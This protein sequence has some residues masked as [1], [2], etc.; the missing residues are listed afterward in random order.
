VAVQAFGPGQVFTAELEAAAAYPP[1]PPL[2]VPASGSVESSPVN[3]TLAPVAPSTPTA[4]AALDPPAASGSSD[5]DAPSSAFVFAVRDGRLGS[6]TLSDL[7]AAKRSIA[8]PR[9][10]I[11]YVDQLSVTAMVATGSQ[12]FIGD[13]SGVLY[14]WDTDSGE[15]MVV[16]TS[17]KAIH[18]IVLAPPAPQQKGSVP[19]RDALQGRLLML[20]GDGSMSVRLGPMHD[21]RVVHE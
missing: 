13:A 4:R 6:I 1:A 9:W 12:V 14:Q 3:P 17:S 15:T 11:Q 8:A 5:P 10:S 19:L 18:K 16:P 2:Q 7:G 20:Y 21:D